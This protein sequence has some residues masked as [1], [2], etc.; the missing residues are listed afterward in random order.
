ME[1]LITLIIPI[2]NVGPYLRQC[3]DSVT[4]QTIKS[5]EIV[6][7][8]DGSTDDSLEIVR[9][10]MSRDNRIKL[11][12][13]ENRGYGAAMND[14]LA[15][16]QGEYVG[17]VEPDD[18][19]DVSM[20]ETL[21]GIMLSSS[22]K[23]DFAKG[24]WYECS[25]DGEI[26]TKVDPYKDFPEETPI[27]VRKHE[28]ILLKHPSTQMGLYRKA[29]LDE[30]G[31]RYKE[32]PGAGW[33]DNPFMLQTMFFSG[34]IAVTRKPLYY[35]RTARP[36][37]SSD[38]RDCSV[39]FCRLEEMF[40]FLEEKKDQ[41]PFMRTLAK[42][43]FFYLREVLNSRYYGEQKTLVEPLVESIVSRI[44]PDVLESS[45]F[46][47]LDREN[48]R[49]FS[50]PKRELDNRSPEV[51]IIVPC[52][53]AVSTIE[54]AIR[55][56]VGQSLQ[57]IEIICV[58][59]GSNDNTR[60][61]LRGLEREDPRIRIIVNAE[62]EC[63]G[64]SA[65]MGINAS[66]G[67][68]VTVLGQGDVADPMAYREL[69]ELA[70]K[71]RLEICKS[72]YYVFTDSGPNK[73]A[74]IE[75]CCIDEAD[76]GKVITQDQSQA[77][78]SVTRKD[79]APAIYK[80]DFIKDNDI[81]FSENEGNL[82]FGDSFF[83]KS[84]LSANRIAC[85]GSRLFYISNHRQCQRKE[86]EDAFAV[87]VLYGQIEEWLKRNTQNWNNVKDL[88]ASISFRRYMDAVPFVEKGRIRQYLEYA[89]R[90][91]TELIHSERVSLQL[92]SNS[93][94]QTALLLM[95]DVD[96]YY[97]HKFKRNDEM[98]KLRKD[99]AKVR[100]KNKDY[101]SSTSWKIGRAITLLPRKLKRIKKRTGSAN[102]VRAVA[103]GN[104]PRVL[105]ATADAKYSGATL[106]LVALADGLRCRGENVFIVLNCHGPIEELL[107]AK[108]IPYEIVK[109][110]TW[111]CPE[112]AY[113]SEVEVQKKRIEQLNPSAIQRIRDIIKERR[114]N[115]VHTN[116]LGISVAAEA[117][118]EE[119]VK[120][121]WHLREF[122]KEDHHLRF[123]DDD[124]ASELIGNADLLICVSNAVY[125][126][127]AVLY[128]AE[129]CRVIYNGID[130]LSFF[131]PNRNL[132][133]DQTIHLTV[134]GRLCEGK[135]QIDAVEAMA[136]LCK[137]HNNLHL[138]L[139]GETVHT[140]YVLY[141]KNLIREYALGSKIEIVGPV[142]H[143]DRIW[144]ETDIALIT[145]RME[146]FGRC[147]VEAMMA[148][149]VVVGANTG[150]TKEILQDGCGYLY[151]PGDVSELV[152][153]LEEILS[154]K[155]D[156]R[157]TALRAQEMA[158]K[159]FSAK[160]NEEE[161]ALAHR[162]LLGIGYCK[163]MD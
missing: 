1:P 135:G 68:Y 160:R 10:Y 71:E 103:Y 118:R 50:S 102:E 47:D 97:E 155:N 157:N 77:A 3:L 29:F 81:W 65:N 84:M 137:S 80:S 114:I 21:L 143:M 154:N 92:F 19:I 99:L 16:A 129:K 37:S 59:S 122:V 112:D 111:T 13:K 54:K 149:S 7:V 73:N 38:L 123:V 124:Y 4:N 46:T 141:L 2:Y 67:R 151:A 30:H 32:V 14:G 52:F 22:E 108:R 31:I 121:I 87:F 53:N 100:K 117:A 148:G 144:A 125:K 75:Y 48:Y 138:S 25:D 139:V 126:K 70:D 140:D 23:I 15:I 83:V 159:R 63:L 106:S 12:D 101:A 9:E 133:C 8:N 134:A 76:Y 163:G 94:R 20:Y 40:D 51:S 85:S 109:S 104:E 161:I 119:G 131:I 39:P 153:V 6:C 55:S 136:A 49:R 156:S 147:A 74:T 152:A 120:H 130:P 96:V 34:K 90:Q 5:I 79:V 82:F 116:T 162:E 35:Y 69:L 128:G 150:G 142:T 113:P 43:T 58:D 57:D 62:E 72:D 24:S 45:M 115:I 66:L 86:G 44:P 61:L 78:L 42:R 95:G 28:R 107:K 60:Y 145:S 132:F 89:S 146:A 17:I 27:D 33:V 18:Y 98:E 91:L 64:S 56:L 36:G 11:I 93:D 127:Y 26:I 41:D 158:V 88:F 110:A 105:F